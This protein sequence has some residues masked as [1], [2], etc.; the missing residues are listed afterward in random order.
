MTIGE[1]IMLMLMVSQTAQLMIGGG[2][3][4][5]IT[6]IISH[7]SIGHMLTY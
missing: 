6:G 3:L 1:L 7:L 4:I 5:A 2:L